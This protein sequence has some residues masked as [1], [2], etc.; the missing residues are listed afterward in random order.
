M[1]HILYVVHLYSICT[2]TLEKRVSINDIAK[3]LGVSITTVSFILNG[4][5]KEK[6]ISDKVV[7]SVLDLVEQVNYKPNTLARSLRTGK[8]NIIGL[9]VE[10][11]ANPFFG[12]IA[13][14]IEG[15]A[16]RNGYKIIYSSTGNDTAKARELMQM[17]RD[18]HVDGYIIVPPEGVESEIQ[19]IMTSGKPVVLLDRYLPEVNVDSVTIDNK[20]SAYQATEHL[21]LNG[22]K[23]VGL[24]TLNSAQP[25]MQDRLSGYTEAMKHYG[26]T[27]RVEKITFEDNDAIVNQIKAFLQ[28]N[29]DLDAVLFLTN[30]L[31]RMGLKAMK[32][33]QLNIPQDLAVVGFDEYELFEMYT[34]TITT[35]AQPIE[36]IAESAINLLLSKLEPDN[37]KDKFQKLVLPASLIARQSSVKHS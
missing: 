36:Q 11:I 34:P 3:Q 26:M 16:Y 20:E 27:E 2:Y 22:F 25:Q 14:L 17:F 1:Q 23:K 29:S 15:N 12:S 10:D 31:C 37:T 33:M 28:A 13:R 30:Y 21:I 9:L 32:A 5:A 7:K 19:A 18:R 24:I 6:R 35:V 8:T 4:R